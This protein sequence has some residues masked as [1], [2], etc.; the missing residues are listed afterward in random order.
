MDCSTVVNSNPCKQQGMSSN[1]ASYYWAFSVFTLFLVQLR[2]EKI[3]YKG[4][5]L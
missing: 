5:W 3:F 4:I 2:L 1:P